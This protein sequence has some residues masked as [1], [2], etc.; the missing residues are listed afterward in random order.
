MYAYKASKYWGHKFKWAVAPS[1]FYSSCVI[2]TE[3]IM[4]NISF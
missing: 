1:D 2:P 3:G 4:S